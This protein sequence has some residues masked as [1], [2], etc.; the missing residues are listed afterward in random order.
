MKYR[1]PNLTQPLFQS[2]MPF[3]S[4]FIPS[5]RSLQLSVGLIYIKNN[6]Y[7]YEE[8]KIPPSWLFIPSL[9]SYIVI[10][11]PFQKNTK[12]KQIQ[13]YIPTIRTKNIWANNGAIRKK[14][15]KRYR[16][17]R[18]LKKTGRQWR[19]ICG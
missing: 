2:Q 5:C 4:S 18:E 13:I 7:R 8:K 16:K 9:S 15:T 6:K 1:M 11:T 3:Q 19:L 12:K 14:K 17:M 10:L